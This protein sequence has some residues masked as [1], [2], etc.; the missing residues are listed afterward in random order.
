[1]Q[2]FSAVDG[3]INP[4]FVH[5]AIEKTYPKRKPEMPANAER[6]AIFL[7]PF[8]GS[9]LESWDGFGNKGDALSSSS[10]V[11]FWELEQEG[12]RWHSPV[13]NRELCTCKLSQGNDRARAAR[14]SWAASPRL[15]R[16]RNRHRRQLKSGLRTFGHG[17]FLAKMAA[18]PGALMTDI[19][20]SLNQLVA[21]VGPDE[22]SL[23]TKEFGIMCQKLG[24]I[25]SYLG[26]AFTFA[27]HDF[28]GKV[29]DIL[30]CQEEF[31]TLVAMVEAD[32]A[33][34]R[35]RV[36]NSHARNLLRVRRG[37]DFV[38]QFFSHLLASD[39]HHSMREPARLAYDHA[40]GPHHP[41]PIRK[42][43]QVGL[44]MLPS[45][46]HFLVRIEETEES[47]RAKL[48]VFVKEVP[49]I[50]SL[51][52]RIYE[53]RNLGTDWTVGTVEFPTKYLGAA[54]RASV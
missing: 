36:K 52:D 22:E 8:T 25:F 18:A 40:L 37:L 9:D 53:K 28:V 4:T 29:V 46:E 30:S 3:S 33:A 15:A 21:T 23:L 10:I 27:E 6:K 47:C 2:G 42:A 7:S 39:D 41:W 32:M 31:K 12:A 48:E 13:H 38:V 54:V 1:M 50:I 20:E 24:Q 5:P 49:P 14:P 11:A 45:R 51:V 19:I 44:L 34:D 17:C 43:V 35:V 26:A 16:A